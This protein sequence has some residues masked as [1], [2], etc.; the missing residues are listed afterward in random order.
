VA[1]VLSTEGTPVAA[2]A[3]RKRFERLKDKLARLA[4]EQGLL[5]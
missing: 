5:G 1:Q 3:L 2:A 4:K